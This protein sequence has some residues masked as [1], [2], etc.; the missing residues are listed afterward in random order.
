MTNRAEV[1]CAP[2]NLPQ[3]VEALRAAGFAPDDAEATIMAPNV[4]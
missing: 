4:K 2:E 3:V 1:L